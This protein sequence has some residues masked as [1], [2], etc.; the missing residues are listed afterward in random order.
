[1]RC[2][3]KLR[4]SIRFDRLFHGMKKLNEIKLNIVFLCVS[5]K[6]NKLKENLKKTVRVSVP[7]AKCQLAYLISS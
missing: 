4:M 1:M 7:P 3:Y 6:A 2:P 5:S